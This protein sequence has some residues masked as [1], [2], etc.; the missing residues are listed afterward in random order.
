MKVIICGAGHVGLSIAQYLEHDYDVS[1]IDDSAEVLAE[2][3]EKIDVKTILG[4]SA[5]P[6]ILAKANAQDADIL[7]AVTSLDETN[8][9]T[10]QMAHQLFNVN[11]KIARLRNVFYTSHA[12]SQAYRDHYMP[13]DVIISPEEEIAQAI[14]RHL[15]VPFAFDVFD[16][17]CGGKGAGL[18]ILGI[19]MPPKSLF[20][21]TKIRHFEQIFPDFQ[22][23]VLRILRGQEVITPSEEDELQPEDEAYLLFPTDQLELVVDTLGLKDEH[24]HQLLIVGGGRVGLKLALEI[25]K[26]HPSISSTLIEYNKA[27]THQLVSQ[28]TSTLVLQGDA[29]DSQILQEAGV[30]FADT[31]VAVTN[32]DKVNILSSL[33]AK[34]HGA[35]RAVTLVS[36]KDYIPLLLSLGI[37]KTLSP[38]HLTISLILQRVRK[39]SIRRTHSLS[40]QAGEVME[41]ELHPMAQGVGISLHEINSRKDLQVNAIIRQGK[42]LFPQKFSS[43]GEG[44]LKEKDLLVITTTR[45]GYKTFKRLFDPRFDSDQA[46]GNRLGI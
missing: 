12:S 15:Q 39:G 22:L 8:I 44:V 36:R 11:L 18:K 37:D 21:F 26:S 9:V 10:C 1:L 2:V 34:R 13:I 45:T 43:V 20:L 27:Q 16:L 46:E 24:S 6:E 28:L 5:D 17:T 32:D 23:S 7:I 29:L 30:E 38:S 40:E 41:V 14:S 19:K 33:L 42:I 4:S 25:E 3:A 31:V 35:R